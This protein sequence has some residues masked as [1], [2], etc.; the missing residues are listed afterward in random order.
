MAASTDLSSYGH[1]VPTSD[2]SLKHLAYPFFLLTRGNLDR[3]WRHS[4]VMGIWHVP[5]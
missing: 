5:S 1:I 3:F 2:S 4:W